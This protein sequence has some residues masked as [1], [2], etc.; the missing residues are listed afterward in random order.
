MTSQTKFRHC[1]GENAQVWSIGGKF[2]EMPRLL[3]E[4]AILIEEN[5]GVWVHHIGFSQM[6]D[7]EYDLSLTIIF[8]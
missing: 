6:E 4:A 5:E 2:D 7:P 1:H 8:S 3:R